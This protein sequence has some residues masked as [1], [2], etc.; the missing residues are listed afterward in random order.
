MA[1]HKLSRL[2]SL[3]E[4]FDANLRALLSLAEPIENR[5]LNLF[6]RINV[7]STEIVSYSK[8]GCL[9]SFLAGSYLNPFL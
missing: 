1:A 4:D 2:F 6:M 7:N 9:T 5:R 3:E 8:K